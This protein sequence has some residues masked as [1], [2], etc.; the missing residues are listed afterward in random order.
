MSEA[1]VEGL[2]TEILEAIFLQCLNGNLLLASPR[3]GK[4]LSGNQSLYR[5]VFSVAF[6]GHQLE[7]VL[8][9]LGLS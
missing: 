2:P 5:T 9:H 6:Y 8:S 3:I 1:F 4:R 7:D